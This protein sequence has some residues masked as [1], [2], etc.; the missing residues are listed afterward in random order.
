MP[1]ISRPVQTTAARRRRTPPAGALALSA[2]LI[3]AVALRFATLSEQSFWLDESY[4]E[5]LVHMS[6][7]GMW[8]TIPATEST[9]PAYYVLAWLWTRV[10]GFSEFG[11]RSLSALAGVLTVLLTYAAASRLT[12]RRAG[13]IAGALVALSPLMIWFSQEARSYSVA[14]C[15]TAGAFLCL[16]AYLDTGSSGWLAGWA[17]SSGLGLTTHYFVAFVVAPEIVWLLAG[18]RGDRR[19]VAAITSVVAIGAALVPLALTQQATGHADYISQSGLVQ[20]LVQ[21]PKQMLIG[22]A[23]PL[24]QATGVLAALLVLA[25]L[26]ALI[27]HHTRLGE[28]LLLPLSVGLGSILVPAA[29]AVL[30]VDFVNTRNLLPAL[31]FLLIVIA[32]GLSVTGPG[33]SGTL[34]AALI[35][36]LFL[37]VVG[38]V[39]T[40]AQYERPDWRG[41]GAALGAASSPRVMVVS[42]GSGLLPLQIYQPGLRSLTGATSVSELDVVAIPP[43][44][45]GSGIGS[46]PRPGAP[47]AVPSGFE[48]YQA[49]YGSTFTVLRYRAAAPVRVAASGLIGLS[50]EPGTLAVLSQR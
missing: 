19:C 7:A 3:L 38:L 40:N 13:L 35:G 32:I 48:L 17:L 18:R 43:Q 2:L 9:P 36:A 46:P 6:F 14:A 8:H 39:D 4:T 20:R 49:S 42:P 34:V 22:Y 11:L 15:A 12:D 26:P 1:S 47:L 44:L 33:Q 25:C 31:P 10:W 23:S 28:R 5:R 21:V 50:L 37:V 29:L 45:T 41:V 30:G 24:Q 16:I 27:R